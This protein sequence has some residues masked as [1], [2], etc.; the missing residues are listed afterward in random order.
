[1]RISGAQ[2]ADVGIAAA[3][4]YLSFWIY[5]IAN[6]AVFSVMGVQSLISF[7]GIMPI[8]T[9]V[10]ALSQEWSPFAKVAQTT[11]ACTVVI[12]VLHVARKSSLK[13]T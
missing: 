5:E 4:F 3:L 13:I 7:N 10:V 1:M 2:L 12:A 8:G 9:T 11:L 6:F